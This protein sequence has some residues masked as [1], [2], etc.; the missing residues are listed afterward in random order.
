ML[1]LEQLTHTHTQTNTHTY[2]YGQSTEIIFGRR[3]SER[4]RD[5]A[6]KI[7]TNKRAERTDKVFV[8][9]KICWCIFI[10]IRLNDCWPGE[11]EEGGER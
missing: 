6:I 7:N 9:A 11:G 5:R 4:T 10:G 2:M 1:P 3:R 8:C